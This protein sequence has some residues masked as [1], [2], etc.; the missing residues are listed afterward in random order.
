MKVLKRRRKKEKSMV[1]CVGGINSLLDVFTASDGLVDELSHL[2]RRVGDLDAGLLE[3]LDLGIGTA[4]LAR[5]D[6]AGVA[7]TTTWWRRQACDERH[8]GL[9]A[10]ARVVRSQV[11][12]CLLL[13][14]ASDLTDQDYSF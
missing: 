12:G 7:H 8:D 11:L 1:V 13:G 4:R 6:G 10:R 14:R 2:S 9:L 5:D 3:R